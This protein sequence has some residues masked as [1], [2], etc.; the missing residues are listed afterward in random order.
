MRRWGLPLLLALTVLSWLPV[1]V[2]TATYGVALAAG[3]DPQRGSLVHGLMPGLDGGGA[4]NAVLITGWLMLVLSPVAL[5]TACA[6]AVI[7]LAGLL[8][9]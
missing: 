1:A 9:R 6:W 3:C 2:I 8:R 7:G 5:L 4:L